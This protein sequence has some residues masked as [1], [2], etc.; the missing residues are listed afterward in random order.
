MVMLVVR[1]VIGHLSVIR[2]ACIVAKLCSQFDTLLDVHDVYC[3]GV[4]E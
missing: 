1:N 2:N 4:D 3:A